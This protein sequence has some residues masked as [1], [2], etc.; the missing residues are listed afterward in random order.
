MVLE[1][2]GA[3][4]WILSITGAAILLSLIAVTA[5]VH[6]ATREQPGDDP[7]DGHDGRGRPRPE[8]PGRDGGGG[9]PSWWPEFER[10]FARYASETERAAAGLR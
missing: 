7:A 2:L 10:E 5:A 4:I 3:P 6:Q 8:D 1:A 9:Q